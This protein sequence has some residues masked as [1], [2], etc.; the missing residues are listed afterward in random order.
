LIARPR[1]TSLRRLRQLKE[2]PYSQKEAELGAGLTTNKGGQTEE[3]VI[4][5]EIPDASAAMVMDPDP[6]ACLVEPEPQ[7]MGAEAI[8]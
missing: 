4:D 5:Q 6:A 8:E 1:L 3:M 2:E 7:Q